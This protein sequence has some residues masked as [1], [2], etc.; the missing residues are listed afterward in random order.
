MFPDL[1]VQFQGIDPLAVKHAA[2]VGLL[3]KAHD[4]SAFMKTAF[5]MNGYIYER[6]S[7]ELFLLQYK[8]YIKGIALSY[9]FYLPDHILDP[10]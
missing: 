7:D 8:A 2:F 9:E 1:A 5:P 4:S 3:Q 10:K 6:Y